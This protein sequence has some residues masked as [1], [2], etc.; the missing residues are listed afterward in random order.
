MKLLLLLRQRIIIIISIVIYLLYML[1]QFFPEDESTCHL[2]A[3]N[4]DFNLILNFKIKKSMLDK[5]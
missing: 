2:S 4:L 3:E 5:K 1:K